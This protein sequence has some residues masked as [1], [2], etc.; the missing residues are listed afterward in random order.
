MNWQKILHKNVRT[1]D[2]KPIGYVAGGTNNQIIVTSQSGALQY[3]IPKVYAQEFDGTEVSL[4]LPG[5][6]IQRFETVS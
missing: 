3:K 4:K 5:I 1:K 2:Y 6:H